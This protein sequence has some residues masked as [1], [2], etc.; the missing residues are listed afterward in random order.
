MYHEIYA[1]VSIGSITFYSCRHIPPFF[2]VISILWLNA[3]CLF[4]YL[5]IA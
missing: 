3:T 1:I 5:F 2:P 4:K